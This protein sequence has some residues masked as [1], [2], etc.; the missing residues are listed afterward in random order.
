MLDG[1]VTWHGVDAVTCQDVDV[2]R[3]PRTFQEWFRRVSLGHSR[4]DS[5]FS[6]KL[7]EAEAP[8]SWKSLKILVQPSE[9]ALSIVKRIEMLLKTPESPIKPHGNT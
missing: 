1:R 6:S 2:G 3:Q 9:T 7:P 5:I 8:K 4:I